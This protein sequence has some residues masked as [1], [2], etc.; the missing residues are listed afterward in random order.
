MS[1]RSKRSEPGASP[2]LGADPG[3][4]GEQAAAVRDLYQCAS[5][6]LGVASEL[7]AEVEDHERQ[8]RQF[9]RDWSRSPR[10]D[11]SEVRESF[12]RVEM[13]HRQLGGLVDQQRRAMSALPAR[14]VLPEGVDP[15]RAALERAD[16]LSEL[17]ELGVLEEGTREYRLLVA[18]AA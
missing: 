15:I 7:I 1:P 5:E 4:H 13:L 3:K 12:A 10:A 9:L 8:A 17:S 2:K 11:P 18:I 6:S 14:L 16:V